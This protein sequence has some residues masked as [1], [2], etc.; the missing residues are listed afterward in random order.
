MSESFVPRVAVVG[1][2]HLG[3]V[4]SACLAS[5][6]IATLGFDPQTWV[7]EGLS[8][9]EPPL[10]EPGLTDLVKAGLATYKNREEAHHG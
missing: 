9:G 1:L 5:L 7:T 4:T 8:R 10:H 2:W 6:G 3:S